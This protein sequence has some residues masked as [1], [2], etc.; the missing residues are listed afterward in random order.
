MTV[1]QREPEWTDEDRTL[2]MRLAE[3]ETGL[4]PCGCNQPIAEATDANRAFR[5][6]TFR[7]HARRALEVKKRADQDKAGENAP[8]GWDDGLSY[9]ID[10]S[11]EIDP[12]GG[13]TDG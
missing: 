12:K 10:D 3:Y 13:D 7:C 6:Q 1:V 4:C 9:Y 2:A 11:F 5:V 8:E